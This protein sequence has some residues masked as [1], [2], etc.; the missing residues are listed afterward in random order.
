[1]AELDIRS[2]TGN[3]LGSGTKLSILN[4]AQFGWSVQ[5]SSQGRQGEYET[6][7]CSSNL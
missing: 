6:K 3:T 5:G 7:C 2:D 4:R 1:M